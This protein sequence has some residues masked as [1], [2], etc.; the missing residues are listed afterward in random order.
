MSFCSN[1]PL[2]FDTFFGIIFMWKKT[3]PKLNYE[4]RVKT[5]M[6]KKHIKKGGHVVYGTN[7]ICLVEDSCDMAF[8]SNAEK[9]PYFILRPLSDSGSVIYI[10]HDNDVLLARIRPVLTKMQAT[11]LLGTET[12]ATEWIDDR[13]LRTLSFR[14]AVQQSD[15]AALLSLILCICRKREELTAQNK[16]TANADREILAAALKAVSEE[17]A[18]SL[19]ITKNKMVEKLETALA[20]D[21]KNI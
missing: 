9:K 13:K 18:F 17:F 16:K 1:Y 8:P 4:S 5:E 3:F 15:P 20:V 11:E 2:K 12:R 21:L 19:E 14:E 6:D 7:G 10:P